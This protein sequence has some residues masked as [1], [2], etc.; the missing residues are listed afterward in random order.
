[1]NL[2]D[3]LDDIEGVL[4]EIREQMTQGVKNFAVLGLR[5]RAL[6]V[7]VYGGCGIVLVAVLSAILVLT[8]RSSPPEPTRI[9]TAPGVVP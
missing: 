9:I 2:N 3:R 4:E 6:E 1:M 7:I 8:I 5:L